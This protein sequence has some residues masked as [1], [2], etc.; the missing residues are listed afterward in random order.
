ME[1]CE[2]NSESC[3]NILRK[4]G[5]NL[6]TSVSLRY[7]FFFLVCVFGL[8]SGVVGRGEFTSDHLPL[9]AVVIQLNVYTTPYMLLWKN[10]FCHV[11]L[12]DCVW[13]RLLITLL[14]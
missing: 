2:E 4:Q 5:K 9:P 11:W 6:M 8:L 3:E 13:L 7:D 10:K 12:C 14:T 1:S